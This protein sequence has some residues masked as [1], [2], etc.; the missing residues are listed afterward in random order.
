MYQRSSLASNFL[1]KS[2]LVCSIVLLAGYWLPTFSAAGERNLLSTTDALVVDD[3]FDLVPGDVQQNHT[4]ASVATKSQPIQVDQ[5]ADQ[6]GE[7]RVESISIEGASSI[8][9]YTI[10]SKVPYRVGSVIS[11]GKTRQL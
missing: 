7:L 8:P 5:P 11:R 6:D 4:S 10:L 2:K 9:Q 3:D 1:M